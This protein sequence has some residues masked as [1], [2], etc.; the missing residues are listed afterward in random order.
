MRIKIR[1]PAR[2]PRSLTRIELSDLLGTPVKAL[3][4]TDRGVYGT[5][6]FMQ[7]AAC[8][9]G[10]IQLTTLLSLE[11]LFAT[12]VRVGE[13]VQIQI[14]DIDLDEGIIKI[15]GKGNRER[16]VFLPDEPIRAL[17]HTYNQPCS[18]GILDQVTGAHAQVFVPS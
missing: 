10:F 9:Q 1:L 11:L 18:D 12:G 3:G 7:A 15:K 6:V 17:L 2:L 16:Q 8:R 13:L 5:K 4:F 14:P